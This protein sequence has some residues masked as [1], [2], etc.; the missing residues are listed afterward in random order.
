MTAFRVEEG[1]MEE[2]PMSCSVGCGGVEGPERRDV[3]G[4]MLGREE[5]LWGGGSSRRIRAARV[6]V[7]D[8]VGEGLG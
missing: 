4:E 8:G 3:S 2:R 5:G 6:R 7:K 1:A